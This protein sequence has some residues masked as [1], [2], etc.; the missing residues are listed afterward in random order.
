MLPSLCKRV[1]GGGQNFPKGLFGLEVEV[2]GPRLGQKVPG[3]KVVADGSLEAG[4]EFIFNGPC[5]K[6]ETFARIAALNEAYKEEG[7]APTFSIRTSVHVHLNVHDLPP[8][9]VF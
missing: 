9:K 2:E 6:E 4:S 5:D 3:W 1:T 7:I 8:E